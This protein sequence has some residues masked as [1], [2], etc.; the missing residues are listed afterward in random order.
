[1]GAIEDIFTRSRWSVTVISNSK[2]D[3][4]IERCREEVVE[5]CCSDRNVV[6]RDC[7]QSLP[8]DGRRE[9]WIHVQ[10]GI[11]I[12]GPDCSVGQYGRKG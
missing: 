7:I 3:A 6:L 11:A 8:G 2:G 5:E 12:D 10:D 1:M 9:L 4:S